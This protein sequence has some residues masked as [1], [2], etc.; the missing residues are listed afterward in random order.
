MRERNKNGNEIT[1]RDVSQYKVSTIHPTDLQ[2]RRWHVSVPELLVGDLVSSSLVE[3]A[4]QLLR[5]PLG[6][7][8][9]FVL[10]HPE[11]DGRGVSSW[12]ER[13]I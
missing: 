1:K 2:I 10:G 4:L 6:V 7:L 11:E 13:Q 3:G 8:A 5:E 12:N 9:S